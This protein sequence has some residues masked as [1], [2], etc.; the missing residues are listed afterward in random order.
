MDTVKKMSAAQKRLMLR[1][2]FRKIQFFDAPPREF[3]MAEITF[4]AIV[5]ASNFAQLKRHRMATL[6]SGPYLP[7]LG[8]TVPASM[9]SAGLE[10]EFLR[11]LDATDSA[12]GQIK[13]QSAVAAD[14]VLTNAHC[15]R[16][17]MKM[18]LREMYHFAR[19]R[20]DEHAQWDIRALAHSLS[21]KVRSIMP[22]T[23]MMLC[24]KSRFA[25]EYKKIF[26]AAAARLSADQ[27]RGRCFRKDRNRRR[28][29]RPPGP[30][31]GGPHLFFRPAT[32]A[33]RRR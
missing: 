24:G 11:I 15:R 23:A 16:V 14:Y 6:L 18:N 9:V 2:L 13:E 25:E 33:G 8:H 10:K 21:E 1:D 26:N 17:L 31:R 7:E 30:A 29:A 5:S 19:L 3:E 20:D 28:R 27:L 22:L 12:Y 32:S 4:Q